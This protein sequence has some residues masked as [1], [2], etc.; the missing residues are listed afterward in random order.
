MTTQVPSV[1][2]QNERHLHDSFG[3][4]LRDGACVLDADHEGDT[5]GSSSAPDAAPTRRTG[6]VGSASRAPGRSIRC[7]ASLRTERWSRSSGCAMTWNTVVVA[8]DR[9]AALLVTIRTSGG[10]ITSCR[11]EDG[12]VTVTWTTTAPPVR[13]VVARR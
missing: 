8:M 2:P 5:C 4:P 11:P 1:L 7:A 13:G 10:T 6:T 3:S 9:L 12:R